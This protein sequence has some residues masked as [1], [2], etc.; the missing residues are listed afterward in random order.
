MLF[1]T[2]QFGVFF[3]TV[4]FLYLVLPHKWQN[5]MLLVASYF[6]YACWDYRF[7]TLIFIST[8]VDF[9]VG[10]W[11]YETPDRRRKKHILF[12]SILFNLGFLGFFKYY[13]FF[14]ESLRGL[15][16][17]FGLHVGITTL[18]IVLPVGISFYTFQSMSYTFDIYRDELKPTNNYFDF[19]LCVAF[20][21]HMVA[22][23]IQRAQSLID[24]VTT[25]RT[26]SKDNFTEG[27]YLIIW[28]LFK[29]MV[30]ADNMSLIVEPIF[31][32]SSGFTT[33]QVFIGALGFAFQIYGDF[34]G[35]SDIARGT[36]RLLGFNLMV[37]FNL[38]YFATSPQDFWRRWHISLSTWLRD[39]LYVSLGGNRKGEAR[40]YFNLMITM[41]LGGLWHGASW[42]FVIWGAYHGALLCA[43]RAL[44]RFLP[45][46]SESE[47]PVGAIIWK[48]ARITF[49][50]G[51]TL[52]G[53]LIFRATSFAQLAEM[54]RALFA[55]HIE[56][57]TVSLC[58]KILFY[59]SALLLVQFWQ[60]RRNN[61]NTVRESPVLIQ[62]AF[63]LACFY[64]VLIFGVFDAQ[65]FIYFQF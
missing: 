26:I 62:T 24:Q 11:I 46:I 54:T 57:S 39:Y 52:Y 60:F 36:A 15:L 53:W 10:K 44:Q 50:F 12:W 49:M 37:N 33:G 64:L 47:Y 61:L 40:T 4:F 31:A 18:H 42:T 56:R 63:Y 25:P 1:N 32:Q 41:V 16:G 38:P 17:A 8:T 30:V 2:I 45:K 21:P 48:W 20:F 13:G 35:Y 27:F 55:F 29:K 59:C 7:L 19:A 14:A 65:S 43:H 51:L 23:P 22:G 3:L 58:A 6:F 9:F 28:G 5:R 34:S